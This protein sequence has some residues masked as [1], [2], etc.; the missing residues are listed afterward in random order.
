MLFSSSPG[1]NFLKETWAGSYFF[2]VSLRQLEFQFK[3][4]FSGIGAKTGLFY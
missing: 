3:S 4:L 2:I 1:N